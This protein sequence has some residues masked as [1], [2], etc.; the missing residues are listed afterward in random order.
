MFNTFMELLLRVLL[1]AGVGLFL[2]GCIFRKIPYFGLALL[3]VVA[4]VALFA[5]NHSVELSVDG[6]NSVTSLIYQGAII[7]TM[8]AIILIAWPAIS[9]IIRQALKI[10]SKITKKQRVPLRQ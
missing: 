10:F 5:S 9:L 7:L 6:D 3:S 4:V 2:C 1:L 8:V